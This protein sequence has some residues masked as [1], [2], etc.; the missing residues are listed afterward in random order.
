[1]APSLSRKSPLPGGREP[2]EGARVKGMKEAGSSGF[3]LKGV[4]RCMNIPVKLVPD[5]IRERSTVTTLFL[6][7]RKF[8]FLC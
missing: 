3:T 1:M 8:D 5:L 6:S 4:R 2:V 7:L